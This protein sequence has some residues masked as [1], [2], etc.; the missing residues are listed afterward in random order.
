YAPARYQ[1][2]ALTAFTYWK[3]S[4]DDGV[5]VAF[6]LGP[7]KDNTMGGYRTGG[8]ISAEGFFGIYRDW[9]LNVKAAYSDYG[10]GDTGAYRSRLFEVSLTR[11]F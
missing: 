10:G 2:Y 9:Y 7:Y 6:G 3:L 8:D 5:S 4:D 11:R 1:R